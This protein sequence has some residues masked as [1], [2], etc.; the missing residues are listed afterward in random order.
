[1]PTSCLHHSGPSLLHSCPPVPRHVW[2]GTDLLTFKSLLSF[3]EQPLMWDLCCVPSV[4]V[5]FYC[6][7]F[8]CNVSLSTLTGALWTK[9]FII[10]LIKGYVHQVDH[11]PAG[12]HTEAVSFDVSSCEEETGSWSWL[13]AGEQVNKW[14]GEQVRCA[15]ASAQ[16]TFADDLVHDGPELHRRDLH[17]LKHN[18]KHITPGHQVSVHLAAATTIS[19]VSGAKMMFTTCYSMFPW[20]FW[21]W[22][23]KTY[24]SCQFREEASESCIHLLIRHHL[25]NTATHNK[26][27]LHS[28]INRIMF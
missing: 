13:W 17:V 16:F 4:L 27:Y 8:N 10:I 14:T 21:R 3:S 6:V 28:S 15:E 25:L 26:L 19:C 1:M 7:E 23:Q 12:L 5:M 18:R 20:L 24:V 11:D 9:C 2:D 22:K